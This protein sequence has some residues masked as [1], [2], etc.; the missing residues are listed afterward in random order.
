MQNDV[1][2]E[3]REEYRSKPREHIR[4]EMSTPTSSK[5]MTK[6]HPPKKIIGSKD[7]G[8]VTRK[9]VNEELCL[10]S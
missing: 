7:K 10:I 3:H 4:V 1:S 9:R 5:N 6:N 8:V 2:I